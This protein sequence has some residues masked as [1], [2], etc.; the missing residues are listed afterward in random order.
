MATTYLELTNEVLRELNEVV[1]TSANFDSAIGIQ[2]FVKDALNRALNSIGEKYVNLGKVDYE[3]NLDDLYKKDINKYIEYNFRDVEILV[4]LDEKFQY[5]D[6]VKNLSHKG[7]HRYQGVYSNSLTQDGAISAYLFKNNIVPPNKA[8]RPMIKKNY[9]GGYVFCPK[10]GK[11][12][13]VFDLDDT[14]LYPSIIMELNI[15]KETYKG[16]II[17]ESDDRNNY[18]SF[19]DLKKRDPEELLLLENAKGKKI[20]L[21][22]RK[23]LDIIESNN[24]SITANGAMFT[25]EKQSLLSVVLERW[26]NERVEYK[27][28]MKEAYKV[29]DKE[30][31]PNLDRSVIFKGNQEKVDDLEKFL[32]MYGK[33]FDIII[34]DGGHTMRQQQISLG[35]LFDAVKSGGYY[36]MEDL[37]TCSGEWEELYGFKTIN[38]G[39]YSRE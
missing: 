33:D 36:I 7:K 8:T 37:H 11:Y 28:K 3:G 2:S 31:N 26:F 14:S 5:I 16:R 6:L 35:V 24:L 1:V 25:Q 29:N 39:N 19:I 32:L 13:Y 17:D 22:V 38:N 20:E 10:A 30:G 4:K 27:N 15:G 9:A 12:D 23:V 34:D 18:L 21:K